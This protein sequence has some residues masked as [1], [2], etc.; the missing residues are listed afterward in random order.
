MCTILGTK[1]FEIFYSHL[2]FI[3]EISG[4]SFLFVRCN[5]RS[6]ASCKS[7]A[8]TSEANALLFRPEP[9]HKTAYNHHDQHGISK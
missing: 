8:K 4:E 1:F 9:D 7:V 3:S 5:V 6:I 2:A